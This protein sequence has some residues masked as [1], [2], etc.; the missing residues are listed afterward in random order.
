MRDFARLDPLS[1]RVDSGAWINPSPFRQDLERLA[2]HGRASGLSCPS[3]AESDLSG[4]V[5]VCEQPPADL[6]SVLFSVATK[7]ARC[8]GSGCG[9]QGDEGEL[10]SSFGK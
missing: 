5:G 7:L 9:K 1:A 10:G 2:L 4:F 6:A 8:S 3:R